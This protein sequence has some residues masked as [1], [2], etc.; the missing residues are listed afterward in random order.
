MKKKIKIYKAAYGMRVS[1]EQTI[2]WKRMT[3]VQHIE[4][5]MPGYELTS[6]G[7]KFIYPKKQELANNEK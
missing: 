2:D 6:N 1:Q 4:I 7:P 3:I 5:S